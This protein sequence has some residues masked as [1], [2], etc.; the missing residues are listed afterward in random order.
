MLQVFFFLPN[1]VGTVIQEEAAPYVTLLCYETLFGTVSLKNEKGLIETLRAT[2]PPK[3]DLEQKWQEACLSRESGRRGGCRA[4]C[5]TPKT[6]QVD[7]LTDEIDQIDHLTD[8]IGHLTDQ[9]D[10]IDHLTDHRSSD[11]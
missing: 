2:Q 10:N 6:D 5:S 1:H 4:E 11:R 7:H 9:I 8:Q 3:P